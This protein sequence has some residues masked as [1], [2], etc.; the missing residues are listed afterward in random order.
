VN[1]SLLCSEEK[2]SYI[3]TPVKVW[4]KWSSLKLKATWTIWYP[5]INNTKT[6]PLKKKMNM[7]KKKKH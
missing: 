3:G 1:N 4:T 5:N 6:P 7:M 2:L